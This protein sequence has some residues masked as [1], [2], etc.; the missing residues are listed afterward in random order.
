MTDPTRREFVGP[1][2]PA[3]IGVAEIQPALD[4]GRERSRN[5]FFRKELRPL[6]ATLV[7]KVG[8]AHFFFWIYRAPRYLGGLPE[9]TATRRQPPSVRPSAAEVCAKLLIPVG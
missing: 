7:Q 4:P 6:L 8:R 9:P 5:P 1:P 3:V 2:V